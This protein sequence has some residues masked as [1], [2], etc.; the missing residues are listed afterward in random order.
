MTKIFYDGSCPVCKREI[1]L[2]R[3]LSL[4]SDFKWYNV[5]YSKSA[6]DKVKKSKEECLKLL[7]VF[8]DNNNL[9]IGIE[10]FII[11]WKKTKYFKVLA[12]LIDYKLFKLPLNFFYK[13]YAN[14]KYKKLY[15]KQ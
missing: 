4:S 8:D 10:A 6:L 13:L 14:K 7:H 5:H 11:I 1:S 2:Y 3:K 15:T 12:Y 9:H